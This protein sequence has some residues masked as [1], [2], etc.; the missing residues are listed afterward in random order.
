MRRAPVPTGAHEGEIRREIKTVIPYRSEI[1][2]QSIDYF[3]NQIA[4]RLVF[5]RAAPN[6]NGLLFASHHPQDFADVLSHFSI[7]KNRVSATQIGQGFF[8]SAQF[9][10]RPPK[11]VNDGGVIG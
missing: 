5:K 3:F 11:A 2:L 4:V 10:L 9:E 7:R 6:L 8:V 1:G